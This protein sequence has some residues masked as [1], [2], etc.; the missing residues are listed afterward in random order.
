M[1]AVT[2]KLK[3]P[4]TNT[5]QV[6]CEH[7]VSIVFENVPP[8]PP[9]VT[10]EDVVRIARGGGPVDGV[11]SQV[12]VDNFGGTQ[13]YWERLSADE[14]LYGM[15][16]EQEQEVIKIYKIRNKKTGL[17]STGGINPNWN[18][19][20]KNWK[21]L[22]HVKSSVRVATEYAERMLRHA[23]HHDRYGKSELAAAKRH[24]QKVAND[25]E[26]VEITT[27]VSST[28]ALSVGDIMEFGIRASLL[29]AAVI[30]SE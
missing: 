5:A 25:W 7:L 3:K 8:L 13:Q 14:I 27:K 24:L 28:D 22:A 12:L 30:H 20:G 15:Q 6:L 10:I 23:D 26:I 4:T 18:K 21:T 1:I 11:M 29:D 9:E 17:F 19:N 2:S 16:L